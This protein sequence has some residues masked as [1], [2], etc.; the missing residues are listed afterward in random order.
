MHIHTQRSAAVGWEDHLAVH[1]PLRDLLR[2]S[3]WRRLRFVSHEAMSNADPLRTLDGASHGDQWLPVVTNRT[4]ISTEA[5]AELS[6]LEF[7]FPF[8]DIGSVGVGRWLDLS[9]KFE[10]GLVPLVRLLDLRG[11]SLE[12]HLAQVGIGFE[13][14]GYELIIAS[15]VSKSQADNKPWEDRVRAVTSVTASVLP[16]SEDE[17]VN[18]L[19]RNYRA[20][21]HADNARPDG[22]EMHL[23]YWQS[24][25]VFRTWAAL[26]LGVPRERLKIALDGDR[27]TR[28]IREIERTVGKAA[29]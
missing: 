29:T 17:F 4:G 8:G 15:G 27:V 22:P 12:A 7:L 21:K 20:V 6:A 1:F 25:Q 2:V 9:H 3:A 5:P 19:R 28:H 13:T 14:L 24:I 10:R 11:A 16:F 26:R 18:L 23:A